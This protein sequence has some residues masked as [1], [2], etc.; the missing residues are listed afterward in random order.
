MNVSNL[1]IVAE[2]NS[3]T[4]ISVE[5]PASPQGDSIADSVVGIVTQFLSV[6]SI[7]RQLG[8]KKGET[9]TNTYYMFRLIACL[10]QSGHKHDLTSPTIS[11]AESAGESDEVLKKMKLGLLDPMRSLH[12]IYAGMDASVKLQ[13]EV[14]LDN[15][16]L[17]LLP[18]ASFPHILLN[19]DKTKLIIRGSSAEREEAFVFIRWDVRPNGSEHHAVVNSTNEEF[20]G[21]VVEAIK[22]MFGDSAGTT[23]EAS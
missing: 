17:M 19:S 11:E 10:L 15:L 21:K 14:R 16:R 12:S 9:L 8:G 18:N 20:K 13:D 4:I 22:S 6:P 1:V 3:G 7:L 5:W 2:I 23:N